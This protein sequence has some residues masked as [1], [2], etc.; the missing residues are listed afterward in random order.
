[1]TLTRN[2]ALKMK[3]AA[4]MAMADTTEAALALAALRWKSAASKGDKRAADELL[5]AERALA[6]YRRARPRARPRAC[7]G[8]VQKRVRGPQ[9]PHEPRL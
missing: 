8:V 7:G 2:S 6:E 3:Q 5:R 4:I 9:L 1:M